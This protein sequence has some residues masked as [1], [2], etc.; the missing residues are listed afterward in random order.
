MI[1][2][3][4][5]ENG[6]VTCDSIVCGWYDDDDH[7]EYFFGQVQHIVAFENQTF[8]CVDWLH[9]PDLDEDQLMGLAIISAEMTN[10]SQRQQKWMP[11][12]NIVVQ[13]H[14]LIQESTDTGNVLHIAIKPL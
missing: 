10:E 6:N 4:A 9:V 5:M 12:R 13:Q 8:L 1:S 2:T 11:V 7:G 3:I 14:I